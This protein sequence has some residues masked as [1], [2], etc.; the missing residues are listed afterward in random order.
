MLE[1]KNIKKTY[2][3][4]GNAVRA[5]KNINIKFRK[6]E[7]VAILG[8]S[9]CG[10][11]TLLNIIGGLDKYTSGDLIINGISTKKF[12]DSNWDA[13]RNHRVGFVF[14]NYNLIPHQT[15]LENV[16][17]ALKLNGSSSSK[18]N[19][20]KAKKALVS[21]GLGDKL[22]YKPNQLSGG[23]CQRV[24]IARA[25]VNDPD[26]ILA[27]EPTGA[28]DSK[29]SVNVMNLLKEISKD[30]LVIM[31]THNPN[32]A[33]EYATRIINIKDGVIEGDSNPVDTLNNEEYKEDL[34][35]NK[36]Y[37][38][39]KVSFMLSLKNLLS[40]KKRTFI[41]CLAGSIGIIGIA[42]IL[43]VSSGMSDYVNKI[44]KDSTSFNYVIIQDNYHDMNSLMNMTK[45]D[46][47]LEEYTNKK[48]LYSYDDNIS[49]TITKQNLNSDYID[50]IDK[51]TK[52][53][54]VDVS[55]QYDAEMNLISKKDDTYKNVST[56]NFTEI[57]DNDSQILDC[58]DVLASTIDNKIPNEY[59]EIAV[60]VDKYNRISKSTLDI[61]GIDDTEE[62]SYDDILDKEIR[63][64]NNND[65]YINKNGLFIKATSNDELKNA[66]DKGIPLK[67]VSILRAKEDASNEWLLSGISYT[68]KLTDYILENNKDSDVVKAQL[69]NP[70]I[71]VTTGLN[72]MNSD[73]LSGDPSMYMMTN[74]ITS[75]DERLAKLGATKI[76][77]SIIIY[78]KDYDSKDKIIEILDDWN[79]KHKD[80]EI[81]YTDISSIMITMLDSMI[82]IVSYVLIAFSSISLVVSSIMIAIVIYNSVIERTKEIGILRAIGARK[83]D[84]SRVFKSEAIIMGLISGIVAL[85]IT[86]IIC[87]IINRILDNLINVSTIANLTIN[88]CIS[89]ILLS[90]ILTF[91]ASLIPSSMAAKKEAVDALRS[92]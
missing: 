49:N 11:T 92:E 82:N 34:K 59:N 21:V 4:S 42:T 20:R 40:K 45:I 63:L 31:V 22:N 7:F 67:V 70:N 51:K 88:I 85:I 50:Y 41:T 80:N 5:L 33:N 52:D 58:Y 77:S 3:T 26:I 53:L 28:L 78:P 57:L 87:L 46:D 81:K 23:Q 69:N 2:N 17:L 44:E 9:G 89:M 19:K 60:V 8:A 15:I 36:S 73:N 37:M 30:K 35:K 86:F 6:N 65:Y 72:F 1:L 68:K 90:V 61:L 56:T 48:I 75:Y 91:I 14:Q 71:D 24:A 25:L 39:R 74:V 10:K 66:Y 43:S 38:P 12:K 32:L 76:P 84:V 62:L 29:T 16:E 54:V 18:K 13:Y 83:K 55:Y 79:N 27:D 47:E 64:I